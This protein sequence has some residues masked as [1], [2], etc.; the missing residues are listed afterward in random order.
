M[1]T[2]VDATTPAKII[3]RHVGVEDKHIYSVQL[4][5]N[6]NPSSSFIRMGLCDRDTFIFSAD[7][8]YALVSNKEFR[9]IM[10]SI[11]NN[12]SVYDK[13]I[14]NMQ[15]GNTMISLF[16]GSFQKDFFITSQHSVFQLEQHLKCLESNQ[17][18]H[19]KLSSYY[20]RINIPWERRPKETAHD[21]HGIPLEH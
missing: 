4:I 12:K 16:I 17:V 21:V 9:D 6:N 13:S 2:T 7:K 8:S 15:Y 14:Y 20:K 10:L 19:K 1:V 5:S 11:G 18:A 3:Y